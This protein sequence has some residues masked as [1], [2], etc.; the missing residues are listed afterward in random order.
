MLDTV[1]EGRG[2][3]SPW[4]FVGQLGGVWAIAAA[5]TL[6]GGWLVWLAFLTKFPP[7]TLVVVVPLLGMIYLL[8]TLT[9]AASPLTRRAG[10]RLLWALLVTV[11]G[12]AGAVFV[13]AVADSVGPQFQLGLGAVGLLSL[14]FALIAAMLSA[15]LAI[16]L[17]AAG[18]TAT[19]G[20][21][22]YWFPA[23]LPPDD[24][25]SR[26]AHA[27]LRRDFAIVTE[28]PGGY[29]RELSN[30]AD[31]N[32]TLTMRR[33]NYGDSARPLTITVHS[34]GSNCPGCPDGT[35]SVVGDDMF[36]QEYIRKSGEVEIH[37][38][39]F[40]STVDNS[41]LLRRLGHSAHQA[42][43]HEVITLLPA[44]PARRNRN[45]GRQFITLW[46]RLFSA[47]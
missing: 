15:G 26:L 25:N 42:T 32:W 17:A 38:S 12:F 39:A 41:E 22:G 47:G 8:G 23:A 18:L 24:A 7:L 3:V 43:D 31:G 28:L 30:P 44:D 33:T 13:D 11:L 16:R 1:E 4:T 37:I 46:A 35:D 21:L 19:L 34:K 45:V 5:I 36:N 29:E 2:R 6:T 14:P 20:F 10:I 9:K 40:G 27:H